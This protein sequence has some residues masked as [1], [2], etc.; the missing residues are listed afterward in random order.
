V[1][2]IT[3]A[4]VIDPEL[5]STISIVLDKVLNDKDYNIKIEQRRVDHF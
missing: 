5:E 3:P 4:N 1:H 2:D